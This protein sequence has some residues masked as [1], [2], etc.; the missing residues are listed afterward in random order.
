MVEEAN[1]N[2]R[3]GFIGAAVSLPQKDLDYLRKFTEA[4]TP[5]DIQGWLQERL[6]NCMRHAARKSG[7]DRIGWL[8]DAAF[9]SVAVEMASTLKE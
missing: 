7:T 8:E 6:D 1:H 2:I 9:F 3:V 5:V 4:I